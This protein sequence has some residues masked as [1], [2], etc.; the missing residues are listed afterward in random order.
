MEKKQSDRTMVWFTGPALM[1]W[2]V[3]FSKGVADQDDG[4][5]EHAA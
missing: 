3:F 5:A 2:L 4:G 1:N